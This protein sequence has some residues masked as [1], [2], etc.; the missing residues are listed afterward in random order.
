M[1]AHHSEPMLGCEEKGREV[2]GY[3]RH[4]V[5]R[6]MGVIVELVVEVPGI[7]ESFLGSGHGEWTYECCLSTIL[8]NEKQDLAKTG[9]I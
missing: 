7:E 2:E 6:L 3:R 1:L 9:S 4:P 8:Q 5:R